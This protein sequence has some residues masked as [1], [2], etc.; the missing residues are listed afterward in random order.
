VDKCA[1]T[2]L[3][4]S[5]DHGGNSWGLFVENRDPN[6]NGIGNVGNLTAMKRIMQ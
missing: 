5:S 1:R 6:S 3:L 4:S 2:W